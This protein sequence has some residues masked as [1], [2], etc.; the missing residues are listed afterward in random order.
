MESSSVSYHTKKH[1]RHLKKLMTACVDLTNLVQNLEIDFEDW[2][3][4]GQ[5]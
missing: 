1:M 3:I 2:D 4:I 5:R